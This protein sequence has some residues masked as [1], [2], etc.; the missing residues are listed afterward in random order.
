MSFTDIL[1]KQVELSG[2][3]VDILL[4]DKLIA[5]IS[6]HIECENARIICGKN[7]AVL[8]PFYNM[9]NHAA[10]TLLRSYADD[11]ELFT[12][13]SK[14]IWPI[15]AK[16]TPEDIYWGTRL[17]CLEMIKSGTVFFNDMYWHQLEAVKAADEMGMRACVGLMYLE[18]ENGEM[19]EYNERNNAMVM[20]AYPGF[21]EL[22]TLTLAPHAI[23]TVG[24]K[25]L[26]SIAAMSAEKNLKVH[27]HVAET[28]QEVADCKKA[29]NGMTP[30]EYLD[31]VGLVNERMVAAH[32]VHMSDYD[33]DLMA[34]NKAVIAHMPCSNM[35]LNSGSFRWK[36]AHDAG[37][38]VTIGTDGCASNNNLS[39]IEE[40][41]FAALAAK[42]EADSPTAAPAEQVFRAAT[43]NGAQAFNFNAGVVAAGK[44]ADLMLVNLNDTRLT[45]N[46]LIADMVYSADSSCIDSVICNGRVLMQNGSVADEDVIVTE[47][48]KC[49]RRLVE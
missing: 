22:I 23:Y 35:K 2:R 5:E 42:R 18:G 43:V 28:A 36:A 16:M 8:P 47:V 13:L 24:E 49:I 9:H 15:E 41:K 3:K 21:S 12:W 11:M 48:R 17:A 38:I 26:R 6:P 7:K 25:R 37:C 27:I 31:S 20:A 19:L 14:H 1:I 4:R 45:G 30:V 34:R 39:M 46:N 29:H 32:C 33:L 40:M 10:M 44:A